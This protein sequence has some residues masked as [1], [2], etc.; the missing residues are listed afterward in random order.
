MEA[1][2]DIQEC[3][4][5]WSPNQDNSQSGFT[6]LELLVTT[7]L[8]LLLFAGTLAAYNSFANRQT[9]I[10]S[11]RDV[12][13]LLQQS[14]SRSRDGDKPDD[15]CT[16]LDGYRVW[17]VQNSQQYYLAIRCDGNAD[18][19]ETQEFTLQSGEVFLDSFDVVFPPLP[20]PVQGAPVTIRIGELQNP[21]LE[22]DFVVNGQGVVESGGI[23]QE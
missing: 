7:T 15:D 14:Q 13:S 3:A 1:N 6:F 10:D 22:Y 18:N 9:K 12:M 21:D 20:G 8:G 5:M 16:R 2:M 19:L 11:A 4:F 23:V 17:G